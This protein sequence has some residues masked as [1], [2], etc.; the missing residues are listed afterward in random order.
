MAG[1]E[2]HSSWHH[3]LSIFAI[4]L[5]MEWPAPDYHNSIFLGMKPDKIFP[6]A[7]PHEEDDVKT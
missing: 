1:S 2:A 7:S 6:V 5:S 4:L 3:V